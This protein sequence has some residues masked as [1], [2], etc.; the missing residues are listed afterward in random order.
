MRTKI[1][2]TDEMVDRVHKAE[3]SHMI[4]LEP[5]QDSKI[6]RILNA[7]LN[8]DLRKGPVDRRKAQDENS[9]QTWKVYG[10]ICPTCLGE[11]PGKKSVMD[12]GK[13]CRY[14]A[15]CATCNTSYTKIFGEAECN[16][17][18]DGPLDLPTRIKWFRCDRCG[19]CER[20]D[21]IVNMEIE[22][23][24]PPQD[25]ARD[26]ASE[27]ADTTKTQC[28]HGREMGQD[29]HLCGRSYAM[30]YYAKCAFPQD[31]AR[32]SAPEISEA[33]IDIGFKQWSDRERYTVGLREQLRKAFCAMYAEMQ[34]E[35]ELKDWDGMGPGGA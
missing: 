14:D 32:T 8:P 20:A 28:A 17:E 3:Y 25:T 7:A 27:A 16:H 21:N 26:N 34:K 22:D 6:R 29:C 4:G 24:K 15:H 9:G 1:E 18:W 19:K 10:G 30:R 35:L 23:E 2:I 31:T 11:L 13:G 5:C 12:D 33:I